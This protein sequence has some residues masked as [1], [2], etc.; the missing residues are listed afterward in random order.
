MR[1]KEKN[2]FICLLLFI[3][4]AFS[5]DDIRLNQSEKRLQMNVIYRL[6]KLNAQELASSLKEA[7]NPNTAETI[8]SDYQNK[9][10]ELAQKCEKNQMQLEAVV[11]RKCLFTA[12]PLCL[13]V[14]LLPHA[15]AIKTLP[16]DSSE[17]QRRWF[18]ELWTLRTQYSDSMYQVALELSKKK[19]GYDVVS[20]ILTTLFINPDHQKAREF[21]GY[22]LHNGQ[23]FTK[24]EQAQAEKGL[25]KTKFFG[26]I[27]QEY[28]QEYEKG[29]RFYRNH[30]YSTQE[31][32]QLIKKSNTGWQLET[33]HFSVLSR[34]SLERSAEICDFLELYYQV[35]SRLF[36]RF[37]ATESQWNA[38]MYSSR[39]LV[40]KQHKIIIYRSR[41]EYLR[42]LS[43]Y[44]ANSVYS[45][46]GYFPS[47][48]CLFIYDTDESDHA[49]L[50]ALLSHE[51]THQLF[52]ECNTTVSSRTYVEHNKRAAIAN[53]WPIEGIAVYSESFRFNTSHDMAS[54]GTNLDNP[55]L[56]AAQQSLFT[57][58]D[59]IPLRN[60][61]RLSR[62]Q[63]Q[64]RRDLSHLYSQSAGLTS[65][66]MHARNGLYRN[67]FIRYLQSIYQGTDKPD[68]L[69][70]LT[71]KTFEEL[72]KEYKDFMESVFQE[73]ERVN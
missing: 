4:C 6:D 57:Q 63:F 12:S 17:K 11:T 70:E 48:H 20:C 10:R 54:L 3:A 29:R 60:Y 1:F 42:E 68:S 49:D 52:E 13:S 18:K 22:S 5:V 56:I 27:P 69:E 66:F 40:S 8:F 7:D 73:N 41:E 15:E 62:S 47:L 72:D 71:G 30:W 50:F 34:I 23:W 14:P 9:I 31:V 24:W 32:D 44:D 46:G 39:D 33:E 26:W 45:I 38:R 53:F 64:Q 2:I 55:R 67:A 28:V 37:V 65:F 35:W 59:Y 58:E 25:V 36:Y 51:A 61:S 21:L 19:K 43:K 16:Q